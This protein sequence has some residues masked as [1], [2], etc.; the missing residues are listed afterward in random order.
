MRQRLLLVAGWAAAAVVASLVST[1]AVAVAGGQVTDRPLR[2]LS[3]SEVAALT[4][5]CGSSE[6]A[7]CLRQLDNS[8]GPTT[9]VPAAP[10]TNSSREGDEDGVSPSV[11]AE[12]TTEPPSEN[13]LDP[14]VEVDESLTPPTAADEESV[15]VPAPRAEVVD[16]IGGRVSV[17]GADGEVRIIWLIPK[18]GFAVL[19]PAGTDRLPDQVTVVLSDGSHQSTLVASW[20]D[21][22]GLVIESREGGLDLTDS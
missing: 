3:A 22:E 11:P 21:S 17:S 12:D 13:P 20:D 4:E 18:H 14:G 19:P 15:A 9:S 16:L 8:V 2:P 1:G 7:P 10:D 5:E 6:R